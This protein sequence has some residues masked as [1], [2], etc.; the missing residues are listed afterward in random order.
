VFIN[1]ANNGR[2][3]SMGFTPFGKVVEG[4]SVVDSL[5]KGYG[6]GAP[7]GAGPSQDLLQ[8]QGAAYWKAS[9]PNL[10]SIK[11]AKIE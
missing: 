10:D 11:S 1:F 4:M 2:L 8:S 3:D 9:F 7:R 5:Y 6:E